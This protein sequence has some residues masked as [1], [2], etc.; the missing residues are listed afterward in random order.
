MHVLVAGCGWLGTAVAARLLARGDRVT[1]VRSDPGRAEALRPLGIEPLALDL[2]DPAAADR[3]PDG[4]AAILALQA[5]GAGPDGYRRAY[6]LANATLLRAA[7]RLG[8]GALVYSGSTGVFGQRDGAEVDEATA[9]AP[10]SGTGQVLAEAERLL[11]DAAG[12][13]VPV[14]IVRLSGLYGPGRTGLIGRVRGG[15][16]ALGPGDGA[17]MN[18][19]HRDDAVEAILAAL[20][21]GRDGAVYHASDAQPMRRR[22]VVRYV[23]AGL[24][25]A[26]PEAAAPLA[27][28]GPDRRV[29]GARTRA[30]LALELHWPTL[31]QGL[32]G[33]FPPGP[34]AKP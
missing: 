26:P 13:G 28:A 34:V 27:P 24:G 15:A 7:R 29:S 14:R 23:A 16:L 18:F 5:A 21:R 19:C 32:A 33:G 4:V 1:G 10:A 12:T 3:I 11:L 9:P 2:A 30:E 20:D 22:E 8:P 31:R 25:I 6:L 17:W